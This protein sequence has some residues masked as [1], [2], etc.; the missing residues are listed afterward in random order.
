VAT[1]SLDALNKYAEKTDVWP[2][3]TS[4]YLSSDDSN[5]KIYF[6]NGFIK[7]HDIKRTI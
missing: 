5:F 1:S 2:H 4:C 3:Y 6:V 7:W